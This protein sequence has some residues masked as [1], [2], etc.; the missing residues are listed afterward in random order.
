MKGF[1]PFSGHPKLVQKLSEGDMTEKL[2]EFMTDPSTMKKN[3]AK[4]GF[5]LSSA[6]LP[7]PDDTTDRFLGILIATFYL[8]HISLSYVQKRKFMHNSADE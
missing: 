3:K 4:L 7:V 5:E 1:E 8:T 6:K 2:K